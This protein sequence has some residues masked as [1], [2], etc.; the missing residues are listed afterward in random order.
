MSLLLTMLAVVLGSVAAATSRNRTVGVL[1]ILGMSARQLRVLSAWE[2]AP[3]AITAVVVGTALGLALPWI[4]TGVL[5]LR[6]FVGGRFPPT[7]A[8]DPLWVG[9][10]VAGFVVVVVIA[11]L[12]AIALG[13]RFAPAGT[14]KMGEG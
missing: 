3:V 2:L 7:P 14:L 8:I 11:G 1:R 5:D 13:R 9:A 4:V 6:P 12:V 10:A